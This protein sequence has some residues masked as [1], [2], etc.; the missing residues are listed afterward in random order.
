MPAEIAINTSKQFSTGET[1]FMLNYGREM[2]TAIDAA[3]PTRQQRD[4]SHPA[5]LELVAQM[6]KLHEQVRER[7]LQAQAKQ[8]RD[9]AKRLKPHAYAVG[10][11]VMLSTEHLSCLGARRTPKLS[12]LFVGPFRVTRLLGI[13][14]VELDLPHAWTIHP[15]INIARLKPFI[16][17]TSHPWRTPLFTRPEPLLVMG[18]EDV[19]QHREYEIDSIIGHRGH[20]ARM[21]YLVKWKGYS[22]EHASW[23]GAAEL[24]H[25]QATVHA[26]EARLRALQNCVAAVHIALDEQDSQADR[27]TEPMHQLHM[28]QGGRPGQA[29]CLTANEEDLTVDHSVARVRTHQ[30]ERLGPLLAPA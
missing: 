12:H 29:A 17:S 4:T 18:D 23:L 21:R 15:R 13:N 20:G 10:D 5:A 24:P 26:Y 14:A 16:A 6:R 2:R 8:S 25:A 30:R 7:L 1:P 9:S 22:A 19:E 11:R 3:L 28:L 27:R